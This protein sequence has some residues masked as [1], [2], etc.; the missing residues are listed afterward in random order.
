MQQSHRRIR[1]LYF[2]DDVKRHLHECSLLRNRI[3][4]NIYARFL[5]TCLSDR[6]IGAALASREQDLLIR[7]NDIDLVVN[8]SFLY[9]G[10]PT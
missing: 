5:H 9:E 1:M 3:R 7:Q 4:R 6:S 10:K 2:Y 8:V